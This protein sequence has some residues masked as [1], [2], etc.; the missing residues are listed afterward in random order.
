[1]NTLLD[2]ERLLIAAIENGLP[3]VS[4]PYAAIG[5]PLGMSEQEVIESLSQLLAKGIIKR[6]GV[7]VH[8]RHLGY[9]ANAM[10]VWDIPNERVATVGPQIKQ[11]EWVTLCYR[12]ARHL[13][14]WPYNFYCMVHGKDRPRVLEKIAE[15]IQ[16]CDLTNIPYQI[17]FSRRCFKQKGAAYNG[18]GRPSD[19]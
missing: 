19:H 4:H 2:Q 14:K 6:L 13:P 18:P 8:H 16:R 9:R 12:R 3:L 10:I 7:I 15:L 5:Q 17:L 11:C 1:M